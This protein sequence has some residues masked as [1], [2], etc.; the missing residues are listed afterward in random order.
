MRLVFLSGRERRLWTWALAVTV[1]ISAT[2]GLAR[3]LAG[4][5]VGNEV[6]GAAFGLGA[7]LVLASIASHGLEARPGGMEI[8]VGLGIVATYLLVFVRIATPAER[9]HLVEYG[10]LAALIYEALSERARRG[11][12]VRAPA[13]SAVAVAVAI[14]VLDEAIQGLL[15][16]RVFD[17]RDILF[18]VLASVM[19]VLGI[20]ALRS[21]RR[22]G[23]R[24][25]P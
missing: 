18:N 5:L 22:A 9:T 8:A 7:L 6:L 20:V 13:A 21:A 3:S 1:A 19:A 15:P 25:R 16:Q 24:L 23:S 12:T 10:V 2:L 4:T 17:P 11:G 14:G